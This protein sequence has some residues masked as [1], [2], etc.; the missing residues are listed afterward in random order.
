[1]TNA[2]QISILRRKARPADRGWLIRLTQRV[3]YC[4]AGNVTARAILR[5]GRKVRVA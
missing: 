3:G 1:M 2:A 4:A 5:D